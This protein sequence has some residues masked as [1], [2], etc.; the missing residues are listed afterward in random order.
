MVQKIDSIQQIE[1]V[2]L[3]IIQYGGYFSYTYI[4][5]LYTYTNSNAGGPHSLR[6]GRR[7]R[8]VLVLLNLSL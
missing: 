3:R 7:Q 1:Q 8:Y 5:F 6:P 4:R 2:V